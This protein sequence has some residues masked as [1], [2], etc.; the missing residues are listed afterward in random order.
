MSWISRITSHNPEMTQE[1]MI[2]NVDQFVSYFS[3]YMSSAAMAGILGNMQHESSGINPGQQEIGYGG[4]TSH[5][6]GLIQWTPG[7]TLI[8]WCTERGFNWYDGDAQL[9]RIKCEGENIEGA[10]GTFFPGTLDG[11]RYAYTWTQF[12]NLNNYADACLAY[13]AE[14]ERAGI[15]AIDIRLKYAQN[16]YNYLVGLPYDPDDPTNPPEPTEQPLYYGAVRDLMRRGV[17]SNGK[18]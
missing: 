6:Y 2:N 1:E 11:K 5:G 4:S 12:R 18:L 10:G 8:D 15:S 14:R 13:L 16:W 7:Q 17:I 9:Y 3:G